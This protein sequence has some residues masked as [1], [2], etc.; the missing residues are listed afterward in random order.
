MHS[1]KNYFHEEMGLRNNTNHHVP[2]EYKAQVDRKHCIFKLLSLSEVLQFGT[3]CLEYKYFMRDYK[4]FCQ[5]LKLHG[6]S[7]LYTN[8]TNRIPHFLFRLFFLHI[9]KKKST[10]SQWRPK[11]S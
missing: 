9:C 11:Q 3:K 7:I 5:L 1:I 4:T 2:D 8:T 10:T 6:R